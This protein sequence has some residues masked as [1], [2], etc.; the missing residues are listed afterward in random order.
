MKNKIRI[1]IV[2]GA[3]PNF[4][5][6]APIYRELNKHSEYFEVVLLHTGQHY[7]ANM[8]DVFFQDLEIP[9]PDI[10]L[11]I[12]SG[13]HAGQTAGVMISFEKVCLEQKPELVIVVGDVNS[14]MACAITAA[15]LN[16]PVAHVEAGLR[17][18]DR[19]MPEEINRLVT[20]CVSSLLFTTSRDGGENLLHE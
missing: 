2:A 12:G 6:V 5:K 15:K 7:D 9:K 14:T 13:S 19:T 10:F 18:G 8:S 20:D 1:I 17:S 16:I 4:M 3:R 11:G